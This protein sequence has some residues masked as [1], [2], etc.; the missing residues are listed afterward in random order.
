MGWCVTS[1]APYGVEGSLIFSA[2][3]GVVAVGWVMFRMNG[4]SRLS[5]GMCGAIV[6]VLHS[7]PSLNPNGA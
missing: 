2:F 1:N 5:T 7:L 6:S 4:I 3:V